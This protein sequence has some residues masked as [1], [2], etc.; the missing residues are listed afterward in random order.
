MSESSDKEERNRNNEKREKKSRERQRS[1]AKNSFLA[2]H[3][4]RYASSH[5]DY[6]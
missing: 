4:L 3:D 1:E 6:F 5:S 2:D